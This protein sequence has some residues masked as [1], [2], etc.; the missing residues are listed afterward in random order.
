MTYKLLT[1]ALD[2][3]FEHQE[4]WTLWYDIFFYELIFFLRVVKDKVL[5]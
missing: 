1:V 2:T 5:C 3:I 4:V